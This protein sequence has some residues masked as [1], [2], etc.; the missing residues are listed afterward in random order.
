MRTDQRYYV[1]KL[2]NVT[3]FN[4]HCPQSCGLTLVRQTCARIKFAN[5]SRVSVME[6]CGTT[7]LYNLADPEDR[8]LALPRRRQIPR[9]I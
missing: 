4:P 1:L 6:P 3:R 7:S 8:L 2:C 9:D 5:I